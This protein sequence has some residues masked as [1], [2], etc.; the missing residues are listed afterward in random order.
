MRRERR[1][2]LLYIHIKIIHIYL[3]NIHNYVRLIIGIKIQSILE[4][5]KGNSSLLGHHGNIGDL[6]KRV[7]G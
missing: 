7:S 3:H 1:C 4:L 2:P 6:T 5:R